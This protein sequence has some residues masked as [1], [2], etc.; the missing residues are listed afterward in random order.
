MPS[1]DATLALLQLVQSVV[2]HEGMSAFPVRACCPSPSL[3]PAGGACCVCFWP[4]QVE[5]A[6]PWQRLFELTAA[7]S[8]QP[9]PD[10][11][12][13]I[14]GQALAAVPGVQVARDERV[15]HAMEWPSVDAFWQA[16]TRAGPWHRRGCQGCRAGRG[17]EHATEH[18]IPL[19]AAAAAHLS[20]HACQSKACRHMPPS[21]TV[22]PVSK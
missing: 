10:W 3:R 21:L 15:P 1:T 7:L 9:Q 6:G 8:R 19:P 2:P 16:M 22:S 14:P 13:G 5:P 20:C 18:R 11:E 4:Q 17:G 12:A